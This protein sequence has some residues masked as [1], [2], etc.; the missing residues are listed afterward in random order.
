MALEIER[1]LLHNLNGDF[2]GAHREW[3]IRWCISWGCEQRADTL[4][5]RQH[6]Q[7]DSTHDFTSTFAST[8]T[9]RLLRLHL[10][11]LWQ[12][13][14]LFFQFT[15]AVNYPKVQTC[16]PFWHCAD[17]TAVAL[18]TSAVHED[19]KTN[20]VFKPVWLWD[21]VTCNAT[22]VALWFWHEQ[23]MLPLPFPHI[24]LC[25]FS[26]YMQPLGK[27][28]KSVGNILSLSTSVR[29]SVQHDI[30]SLTYAQCCSCLL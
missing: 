12:I 28:F 22:I 11:I 29:Y 8:F 14:W 25:T 4:L 5:W 6:P 2:G 19:Y 10:G 1:N 15:A 20:S 27:Y 23:D 18:P 17:S 24:E 16:S 21:I 13:R 26:L 3:I 30:E 7:R 9:H